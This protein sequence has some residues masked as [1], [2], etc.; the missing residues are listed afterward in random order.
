MLVLYNLQGYQNYRTWQFREKR[1]KILNLLLFPHA[2]LPHGQE[3]S[4]NQ[5]NS[6]KTKKMTKVR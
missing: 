4:G 1:L 3:K 5:E 6:E 2:G